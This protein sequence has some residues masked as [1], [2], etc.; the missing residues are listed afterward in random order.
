MA[1]PKDPNLLGDDVQFAKR[2]KR[3][4][5]LV[6]QAVQGT[7]M[8]ELGP[9][10]TKLATYSDTALR[11]P[12]RSLDVKWIYV[13]RDPIDGRVLTMHAR[14]QNSSTD[15]IDLGCRKPATA[16]AL[17]AIRETGPRLTSICVASSDS[18]S[19]LLRG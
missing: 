15:P 17:Q 13:V 16:D 8:S 9:H 3:Y 2:C 7:L 10:F 5:S 18:V 12:D 6:I 1:T 11:I 19:R 14:T 4:D